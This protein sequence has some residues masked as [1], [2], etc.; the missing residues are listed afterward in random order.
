MSRLKRLMK[1]IDSIVENMSIE[2][3][4][5]R[6]KKDEE[7]NI[8]LELCNNDYRAID[9]EEK[10]IKYCK[11]IKEQTKYNEYNEYLEG[12][13]WTSLKAS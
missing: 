2:E 1:K 5:E 6:I 13:Q 3:I 8:D 7:E 12:T 10:N 11:K 9:Y 4:E